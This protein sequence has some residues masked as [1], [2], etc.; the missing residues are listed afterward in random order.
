MLV[1]TKTGRTLKVDQNPF[2]TPNT[3]SSSGGGN[4]SGGW[5]G[6][7]KHH[8]DVKRRRKSGP[9]QSSMD[10]LSTLNL[11]PGDIADASPLSPLK[12]ASDERDDSTRFPDPVNPNLNERI[13]LMLETSFN[14]IVPSAVCLSSSMIAHQGS[15][16][17][18][19]TNIELKKCQDDDDLPAKSSST[20]SEDEENEDESPLSSPIMEMA[21]VASSNAVATVQGENLQ[22]QND[23]IDGA[24][25]SSSIT[26]PNL[27]QPKFP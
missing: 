9:L 24:C 16:P 19:G 3:P 14:P 13:E 23:S 1:L 12:V 27:F 21:T 26:I 25:S 17:C 2:V 20:T 4:I 7:N 6:S 8:V 11:I 18:S 10:S 5:T 22:N 15:I